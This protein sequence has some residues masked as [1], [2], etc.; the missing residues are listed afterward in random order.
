[1][2]KKKKENGGIPWKKA[3]F[4]FKNIEEEFFDIDKE[5]GIA[6]I[7]LHFDKVSDTF[8]V[9]YITKEPVLS[10]DFMEWIAS[11]FTII[12]SQ[13]KIE[14]EVSFD[15]YEG[16]S[17]ERLNEIFWKNIL[18]DVK[19]KRDKQRKRDSIAYGLILLGVLFF[20]GMMLM[21]FRWE[22]S[23]ITKTVFSYVSDIATT[24]TFWEAMT[25]LIVE[26]REHRSYLYAVQKRFN[27]VT[28]EKN[29]GKTSAPQ[30]PQG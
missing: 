13:Y 4:N 29:T 22:T 11:A 12:P 8:D 30:N 2:K 9:N 24:V 6:K 7:K 20:I 14:L 25:I 28:F 5:N 26:R 3:V 16:Y 10:D 21:E 1:M 17:E 15:D 27:G 18:L 23:S 19:S